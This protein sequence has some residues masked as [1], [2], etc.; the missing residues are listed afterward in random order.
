MHLF[1]VGRDNIAGNLEGHTAVTTVVGTHLDVLA[2]IALLTCGQKGHLNL[3]GFARFDRLGRI[4]GT[5]AAAAGR[6]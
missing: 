4:F 6:R 2:D 5:R 3:T 1:F